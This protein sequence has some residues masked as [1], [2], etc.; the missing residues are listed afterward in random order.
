[1]LCNKVNGNSGHD[2]SDV[3]YLASTS[4]DAVLGANGAAWNATTYDEFEKN[5]TAL[6]D[7]LVTRIGVGSKSFV[8]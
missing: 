1:M 2:E 5:I 8:G 3:L 6:A 7:K 4:Q